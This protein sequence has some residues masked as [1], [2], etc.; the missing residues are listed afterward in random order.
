MRDKLATST[1]FGAQSPTFGA[2]FNAL[3]TTFGAILDG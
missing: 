2:N 3:S 1:S